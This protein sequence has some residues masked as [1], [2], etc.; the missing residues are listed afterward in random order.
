MNAR[1]TFKLMVSALFGVLLTAFVLAAV[2]SANAAAAYPA[3][4]TVLRDSAQSGPFDADPVLARKRAT[5]TRCPRGK[6]CP[7]PRIGRGYPG[8][9]PPQCPKAKG[10]CAMP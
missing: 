7:A 5:P 6:A 3:S 2:H 4:D 8:H 9:H 1:L 10:N